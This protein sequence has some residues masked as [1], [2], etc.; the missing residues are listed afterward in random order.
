MSGFRVDLSNVKTFS[1]IRNFPDGIYSATIIDAKEGLTSKADPQLE[2]EFELFSETH[3]TATINQNISVNMG[4]MLVPFWVALN[5]LTPEE[6][7][8]NPT[9][10][11]KN[12]EALKGTEL[13]VAIGDKKNDRYLDDQGNPRVFKNIVDPFFLPLSRYSELSDAGM[14]Q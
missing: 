13:L 9:M 10:E 14:I 12:P 2:L 1:N 3:G 7:A 4:F 6:F 5:D 11:V 8:A